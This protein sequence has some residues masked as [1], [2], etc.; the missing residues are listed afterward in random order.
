MLNINARYNIIPVVIIIIDQIKTSLM[1]AMEMHLK[2]RLASIS[3]RSKEERIRLEMIP[4]NYAGDN[5]LLLNSPAGFL[6][7]SHP[8]CFS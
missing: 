8:L 6:C 7:L 3:S 2:V 5:G 4:G 1:A